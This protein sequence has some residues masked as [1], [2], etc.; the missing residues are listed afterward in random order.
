MAKNTLEL[1]IDLE[2]KKAIS[3]LS[4]LNG[5]IKD[6]IDNFAVFGLK[7]RG[8]NT[9]AGT[10]AAVFVRISAE[11]ADLTAAYKA[12]AN[13]EVQLQT[14]AQNNPYLDNSAVLR[15]RDYAGELQRISVVGDEQLLPFMAQLAASGRTESEIMQIMS[16]ALD[17]SASG[18]ISLDSAVQGLN[19]SYSG[20]I[21]MLGRQLP[22]LK[23]LT[24][25]ELREGK[26]VEVVAQSYKGMAEKTA[27][28]TGS[29]DQLKN[30]IGDLKEE[31][32]A[33]IERGLAPWNRKLTELASAAADALKSTRELGDALDRI[34]AGNAKSS[35][36]D[37]ALAAN[38]AAMDE[39]RRK[40]Q[41][42]IALYQSGKISLEQYKAGVELLNAA[43]EENIKKQREWSEAR[44]AS[45][46][47]ESAD[48][49]AAE[50]LS[51]ETAELRK[52]EDVAKATEE[53]RKRLYGQTEEGQKE[54]LETEY[55]KVLD[56][57]DASEFGSEEYRQFVA[58]KNKMAADI[59]ELREMGGSALETVGQGAGDAYTRTYRQVIGELQSYSDIFNENLYR[60]LKDIEGAT[61]E[62]AARMTN[63][64]G[65]LADGAFEGI[66]DS[67]HEF[68]K[69][70]EDGKIS[71]EEFKDILAAQSDAI[72][73]MLPILFLQAGLQLI[74]NGQW[75][76]GLGFVAAGLTTSFVSGYVDSKT[77]RSAKGNVF[78]GGEMV[79]FSKGGIA[80]TPQHFTM[81]SGK[82]AE[83]GERGY[84]A[85]L[86]LERTSDGS[87]GVK[88]TG[89][90]G[91]EVTI[92]I[93]NYTN[94]EVETQESTGANGERELQITIGQ[95]LRSQVS[96]GNL[97]KPLESRYGLK[98][99]G[100][101]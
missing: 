49:A 26:A 59:M 101:R 80:G 74:A 68:G 37:V 56:A 18:A 78:A 95:M 24:E 7:L 33:S 30:A 12:Q 31:F 42:E 9:V 47:K 39:Y 88:S 91:G 52:A 98:P 81:P 86:P 19:M 35:D 11:V 79:R 83:W 45:A 16:A 66:I 97:D 8:I 32:G 20:S 94:S 48:S 87:L 69:A 51:N 13:A 82:T 96:S 14:A 61:E 22:M 77:E 71:A 4:D 17:A 57:M 65:Q 62:T 27:T 25:E 21:G 41:Q 6:A 72:L 70:M 28:A 29:S 58:I 36:F 23:N 93:N 99:K 5:R 89:G 46:K 55:R 40:I 85:I 38:A 44:E 75:G 100:V 53:W 43:Y 34:S 54:A 3:S 60:N 73:D 2:A 15:L 92:I 64:L 10:A 50:K 1:T 67:S 76:L 90:S 63:M 84:E